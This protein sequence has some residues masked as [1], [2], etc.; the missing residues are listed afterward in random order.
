MELLVP[1]ATVVPDDPCVPPAP[2]VFE[3]SFVLA[4]PVLE[5]L[6]AT[7]AGSPVLA[8]AVLTGPRFVAMIKGAYAAAPNS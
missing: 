6:L 1:A 5:M 2:A 8:A 3:P 4:V 7:E